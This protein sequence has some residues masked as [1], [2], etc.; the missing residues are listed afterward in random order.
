MQSIVYPP[1]G[2]YNLTAV[3]GYAPTGYLATVN[4]QEGAVSTP[5]WTVNERDF[6]GQITR[7]TFGGGIVAE[8]QSTRTYTLTGKLL[9]QTTISLPIQLVRCSG[10]YPW[11]T[12]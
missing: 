8:T 9:G 1:S 12:G 7:E 10:G 4:R 11:V 5:L 3:Y 6:A 2:A